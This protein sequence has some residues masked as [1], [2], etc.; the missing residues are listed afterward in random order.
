M[1]S[2]PL[3]LPQ[4]GRSLGA[5]QT[6]GIA[7]A[8][9]LKGHYAA[10][11]LQSPGAVSICKTSD[12]TLKITAYKFNMGWNFEFR[13]ICYLRQSSS[14]RA[15]PP[16][17]LGF[18]REGPEERQ[19]LGA[20]TT[21]AIRNHGIGSTARVSPQKVGLIPSLGIA[22]FGRNR[23]YGSK[24]HACSYFLTLYAVKRVFLYL[25]LCSAATMCG[26]AIYHNFAEEEED[27]DSELQN[28]VPRH[29][30]GDGP[31]LLQRHPGSWEGCGN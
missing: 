9:I 25:H 14:A 21:K 16:G 22:R 4:R 7:P 23:A 6:V 12:Y 24:P 10:P 29:R 28:E 18:G 30:R 3:K 5:P 19:L 31:A 15:P 26:E 2:H 17:F 13:P 8:H 11:G 27:Y 20:G 1:L